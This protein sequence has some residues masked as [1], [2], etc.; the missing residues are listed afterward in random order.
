MTGPLTK[1]IRR[2]GK[3]KVE[4]KPSVSTSG[5]PNDRGGWLRDPKTGRRYF[6]LGRSRLGS[7]EVLK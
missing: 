1:M 2:K 4:A 6:R 5:V 3:P 7:K